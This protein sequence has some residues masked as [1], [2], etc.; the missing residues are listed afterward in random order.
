MQLRLNWGRDYGFIALRL[1]IFAAPFL[2]CA[3]CIKEMPRP[4]SPEKSAARANIIKA[5][6]NTPIKTKGPFDGFWSVEAKEFSRL[7]QKTRNEASTSE[8]KEISGKDTRYF[9]RIEGSFCDELFFVEGG[10][11]TVSA[12]TLKRLETT[13]GRTI[14]SVVFNREAPGR[15]KFSQ[16]AILSVFQAEKR[17]LLEFPDHKLTFFPETESPASLAALY[18]VPAP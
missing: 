3:A 14:Y 17:L 1:L 18:G 8:K 10:D 9:L 16:G 5:F 7:I 6:F 12:G 4:V 13:K 15:I 2:L 11:Y